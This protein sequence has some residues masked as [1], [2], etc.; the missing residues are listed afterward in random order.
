M[1]LKRQVY[2]VLQRVQN[3]KQRLQE[4]TM[5]SFSDPHPKE[6]L[7]TERLARKLIEA[8]R[9][10]GSVRE[11]ITRDLNSAIETLEYMLEIAST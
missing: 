2:D 6:E 1:V 3:A 10:L 7:E 8:Q 4:V 9:R 11:V 5:P